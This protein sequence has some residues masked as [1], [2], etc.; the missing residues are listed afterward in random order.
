MKYLR[1]I[2]SSIN[3]KTISLN[4]I[5]DVVNSYSEK[6]YVRWSKYPEK[7]L[8]RGYSIDHL[9]QKEHKGLS[10]FP[11]SDKKS[12]M[13]FSLLGLSD[14]AFP[15]ILKGKEIGIDTDGC[16]LIDVMTII[17]LYRIDITKNDIINQDDINEKIDRFNPKDK[18][19]LQKYIKIHY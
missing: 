8:E 15:W 18:D 19:K 10:C 5:D 2:T 3:M 7:D 9:T 4:E 11:L 1:K 12:V 13:Q 6:L 14:G 17:P 16:P